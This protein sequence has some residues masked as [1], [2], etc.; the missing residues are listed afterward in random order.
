MV[1][2]SRWPFPIVAHFLFEPNAKK[3]MFKLKQT[4]INAKIDARKGER[5]SGGRELKAISFGL[6]VLKHVV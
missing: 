2:E 4:S 3:N 1:F 5:R 6:A